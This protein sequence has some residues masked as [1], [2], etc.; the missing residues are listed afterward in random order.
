M[1]P[2]K[3]SLGQLEVKLNRMTA[4][5]PVT[6]ELMED[7]PSLSRYLP[8]KVAE[9]FTSKLNAA[10]IGGNGIAKPLGL[11]NSPS[12]V[13]QAIE[14]SQDLTPALVFDNITKM[15]ARLYAPLR[16]GAVWLI[17]QDLEP[18]MASMVVPGTSPSYPAYLPPGGLSGQQYGTLMGR[19]VM[20]SEHCSA[21]GTPG[22]IILTN[23]STYLTIQKVGGVRSDVSMHLYFDQSIVAFRFVMRVGGQSW[24][25]AAAT[26][27]NGSNTLSN[28][29]TLGTRTA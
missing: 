17:N 25:S 5:V 27:L 19:P 11:I 14:A 22:D 20:A 15:W 9:K 3:P 13:E 8:G 24:W 4:L 26:R 18:F 21:V 10:I 28:I 1:T 29:I 12:V 2:S 7:A 23:L 6:D 16:S